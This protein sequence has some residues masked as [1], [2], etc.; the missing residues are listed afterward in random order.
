MTQEV[1]E[2]AGHPSLGALTPSMYRRLNGI[3]R[4]LA[5]SLYESYTESL[6]AEDPSEYQAALRD[7][8]MRAYTRGG[9][10]V[11]FMAGFAGIVGGS[12]IALANGRLT[13]LIPGIS[14]LT[15]L[16]LLLAH[17][18]RRG[19]EIGSYFRNVYDTDPLRSDLPGTA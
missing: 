5:D 13:F 12:P 6:D 7:V 3:E 4:R 9:L 11:I 19:I 15:V 1:G 2:P 18:M 16:A 10:T 17:C 8:A 14:V